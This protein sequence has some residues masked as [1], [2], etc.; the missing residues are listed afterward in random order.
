MVETSKW[1]HSYNIICHKLLH[2]TQTHSRLIWVKETEKYEINLLFTWQ[3]RVWFRFNPTAADTSTTI[4]V[5]FAFCYAN[6]TG[7]SMVAT[8]ML[9]SFSVRI[10]TSP[11]SSCCHAHLFVGDTIKL[12]STT[13]HNYF[14]IVFIYWMH[15]KSRECDVN[16]LQN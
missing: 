7:L 12:S 6:S 1:N 11:K 10:H 8:T 9:S 15:T 4:I 5:M 13:I 14:T 2:T 3:K 16:L